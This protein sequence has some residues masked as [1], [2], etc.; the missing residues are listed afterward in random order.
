[1]NRVAGYH[2]L[3]TLNIGNV[4]LV[5]A[6]CQAVMTRLVECEGMRSLPCTFQFVCILDVVMEISEVNLG[7]SKSLSIV[8]ISA[9][10]TSRYTEIDA[11][12]TRT[13]Y[14][15]KSSSKMPYWAIVNHASGRQYMRALCL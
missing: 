12:S 14:Q 9:L 4:V 6:D 8:S 10:S 15:C 11:I 1:M 2:G 13:W 3:L 7:L 5:A